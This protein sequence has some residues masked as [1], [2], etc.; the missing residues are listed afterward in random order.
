MRVHISLSG[1]FLFSDVNVTLSDR[2]P[3]DSDDG[4]DVLAVFAALWVIR[5]SV[6]RFFALVTYEDNAI[7]VSKHCPGVL[8]CFMSRSGSPCERSRNS[9]RM[10]GIHW[11]SDQ[12]R[13]LSDR[14]PIHQCV[15]CEFFHLLKSI[16]TRGTLS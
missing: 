14:F 2:F 1:T 11:F 8:R 13:P 9:R 16:S 12:F 10:R 6:R 4:V 15:F 3:I 5:H 7:T